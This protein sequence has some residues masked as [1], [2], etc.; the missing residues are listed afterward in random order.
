MDGITPQDLKA[1]LDRNDRPLLLDVRQDWETRLCRLDNSVHIPIEE[2]EVRA[3]ELNSDDEIVVY[4]HQGVRRRSRH[5]RGGPD[6]Q[7]ARVH[8]G[9]GRAGLARSRRGAGDGADHRVAR[10]DRRRAPGAVPGD[11]RGERRVPRRRLRAGARVRPARG[12]RGGAPRPAGSPRGRAV[13]D[14][15]GA[16]AAPGRSRPRRGT[17]PHRRADHGGEGARVGARQRRRAGRAPARDRA[18]AR[19][20]DPRVRSRG[21]PPAEGAD[22]PL[23]R[24]RPEDGGALGGRRVCRGLRDRRALRGD[25]RV[26][27]EAA[28]EVQ[29]AT[30]KITTVTLDFWGTLLHDPPSSDN[31]Y[32]K[33]RMAD[34]GTVLAAAGL[35]VAARALARGYEGSGAVLSKVWSRNRD[36]PVT[37]HV[38]AILAPADARLPRRGTGETMAMLVQAHARPAL[39]VP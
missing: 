18:G 7:R 30:L 31:R 8:G 23:A 32:K 11:R 28:A 20:R 24:D 1:R 10:R 29:E 33:R 13:R 15:G 39:L 26:P 19:G 21:G 36:V 37:E 6:R 14:P 5:A 16:P 2:I 35:R 4:C 17:A 3:G 25:E 38:R 12:G 9:H 27:R 34:F 22:R